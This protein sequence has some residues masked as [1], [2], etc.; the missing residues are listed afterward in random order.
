VKKI[1]ATLFICFILMPIFSIEEE[2]IGAASSY[3]TN[4]LE[5]EIKSL[6]NQLKKDKTNYDLI[7]KLGFVYHFLSI[8]GK[9]V[10]KKSISYFEESLKIKNDVL[11][12]TYLGSSWT[13]LGRENL[14]LGYLN[15]GSKMIDESFKKEPENISILIVLLT[16]GIGMPD[17]IFS[18]REPMVQ[19]AL[20]TL[21]KLKTENKLSEGIIGVF[22]FNKSLYL[23]KK[24]DLTN[25]KLLWKEVLEKYPSSEEAK[26]S[27]KLLEQYTE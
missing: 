20:E 19:K 5:K 26:K 3:K 10:A 15:K 4:D 9:K 12:Q 22:L 2:W 27:K 16:N 18:K 11:I 17:F 23:L 6:E 7:T 21:E 14:D 1:L 13:L 24:K 8:S 25:A